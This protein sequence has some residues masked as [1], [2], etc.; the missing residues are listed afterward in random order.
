MSSLDLAHQRRQVNGWRR[1]RDNEF[2]MT[3][4]KAAARVPHRDRCIMVKMLVSEAWRLDANRRANHH[5]WV[6][7]LKAVEKEFAD[8][9]MNIRP[10]PLSS[11]TSKLSSMMMWAAQDDEVRKFTMAYNNNELPRRKAGMQRVLNQLAAQSSLFLADQPAECPTPTVAVKSSEVHVDPNL[12]AD[13]DALS[14]CGPSEPSTPRP[15]GDLYI[16]GL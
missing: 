6:A 8:S 11:V 12:S 5:R 14:D 10:C 3:H 13:S 9:V 15:E 2:V 4:N 7:I 1:L 16:P